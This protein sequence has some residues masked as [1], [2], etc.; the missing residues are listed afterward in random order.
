MKYFVLIAALLAGCAADDSPSTQPTTQP[1]SDQPQSFSGYY[2]FDSSTVRILC[3][4]DSPFVAPERTEIFYIDDTTSPL[5]VRRNPGEEVISTDRATINSDG[6]Y[7]FTVGNG[8][9]NFS[10]TGTL[11]SPV[12]YNGEII[13]TTV[14]GSTDRCAGTG[15]TTVTRL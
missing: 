5:S 14:P 6:Q 8:T 4:E 15:L 7:Q 10:Y 11:S 1:Q 3:L 9:Y 2:Q 12:N 13:I